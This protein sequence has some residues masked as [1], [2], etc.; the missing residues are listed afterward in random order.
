MEYMTEIKGICGNPP[1]AQAGADRLLEFH[2]R[3]VDMLDILFHN[4]PFLPHGLAIPNEAASVLLRQLSELVYRDG[5]QGII[6]A[7]R[8]NL[9]R[10][11]GRIVP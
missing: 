1:A 2:D 6:E 10:L 8:R 5:K 11:H 4:C 3:A 9:Q 7:R